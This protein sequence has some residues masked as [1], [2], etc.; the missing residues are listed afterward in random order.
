MKQKPSDEPSGGEKRPLPAKSVSPSKRQAVGDENDD[1]E[2][3][4]FTPP[5]EQVEAVDLLSDS[6]QA[7]GGHTMNP[8]ILF[9]HARA[10]CGVFKLEEVPE[11]F[12][13]KCFCVVCDIPAKDCQNWSQHCRAT[14]KPPRTNTITP[15]DPSTVVDIDLTGTADLLRNSRDQFQ[16]RRRLDRRGRN[17]DDH[18]MGRREQER[19]HEKSAVEMSITEVLARSLARAVNLCDGGTGEEQKEGEEGP[20]HHIS[21]L[22]MD[23][24]IGKLQLQKSFFV[25][26]VRIGW[27]FPEILPPQRQMAIHIIRALKRKLHVVL[28]SPTGTGKSAAILCSVLAWQR[29]QA[30]RQNQE[31]KKNDEA[32]LH[33]NEKGEIVVGEKKETVP[34]IIYCSRTHSQVAQMVAS[35]KKTPYR[36]RMTVLGSRERLCINRYVTLNLLYCPTRILVS[37]L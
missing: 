28:E 8:N 36:P 10:L 1:D 12:C 4:V 29:F 9:P 20:R 15:N 31:T 32:T 30:H 33:F 22:K 35:L 25:E 11:T 16:S 13:E 34:T 3:V 17:S 24:D 23:G 19:R 2:V 14:K 26:G 27:P 37:Y 6:P 5:K 18:A 21:H 7:A